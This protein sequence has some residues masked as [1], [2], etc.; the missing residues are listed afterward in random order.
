MIANTEFKG[1]RCV[2]GPAEADKRTGKA[3]IS[4]KTASLLRVKR[5]DRIRI[6]R[7]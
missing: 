3:A 1:F 4:R 7:I 2:I 6:T 5:G